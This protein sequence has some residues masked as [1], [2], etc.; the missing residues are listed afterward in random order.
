MRPL[1]AVLLLLSGCPDYTLDP[2]DDGLPAPAPALVLTPDTLDFGAQ[3]LGSSIEATVT[4]ANIGDAPLTLLY[5]GLDEGAHFSATLP[6]Q[7]SQIPPGKSL[8]VTISYTPYNA[9]DQDRLRILSDDPLQEE[10]WVPLSG[11]GAFPE[12][13]ISPN[14]LILASAGAGFTDTAR[15]SLENTGAAPLE[16]SELLLSGETF[17]LIGAGVPAQLSP[18]EATWA[19]VR[20]SPTDDG[21]F[22]GQLWTQDNTL[23]GTSSAGLLGASAVPVALCGVT[24]S[25]VAPLKESATWLGA[26][27]FDASGAPLDSHQWR[28]V[29]RP[30]G[31]VAA[32][33]PGGADRPD[34]VP[35]L[36]GE[37]VAELVVVDEAGNTS[38]PCTAVLQAIPDQD[39]WI[40]LY[41]SEPND[42]MD[43]HLLRP[44]GTVRT[45]GDCYYDNCVGDQLDWGVLGDPA[46][47]PS[48]DIDDIYGTGPE[49]INIGEPEPGTFTVMVHDYEGSTPDEHGE[50]NVTV[51]IFLS[52]R[53]VW[54]QTR[55]ISDEDT[56]TGF[57]EISWPDATVT[58]LP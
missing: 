39:L 8:D 26:D 14:P 44:G 50:N 22:T 56:F 42:D 1:L 51:R 53:L 36:A 33:P 43:L 6:A 7:A 34:F 47:D 48:L 38:A 30:P 3:A 40:E 10:A 13:L 16:I 24:P 9:I 49:N 32:I 27:S 46:D 54:T 37:Y 11:S 20:F 41:W 55:T 45:D 4:L 31:S 58:P 29:S 19:E 12:L 2:L 28:L 23:T 57:A 52:G 25:V 35:D 18:G 17:S 5:V 21:V 15:F